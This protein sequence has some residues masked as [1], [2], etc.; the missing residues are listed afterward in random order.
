MYVCFMIGGGEVGNL[1]ARGELLRIGVRGSTFV[2]SLRCRCCYYVDLSIART[3]N[4]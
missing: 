4:P 3:S 1:N 2:P